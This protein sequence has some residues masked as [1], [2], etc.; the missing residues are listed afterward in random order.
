MNIIHCVGNEKF[1][2]GIIDVFELKAGHHVNRYVFFPE[3]NADKKLSYLKKN[4]DKVS[5]I[6]RRKALQYVNSM[7]CDV[8]F[9]HNLST[10]PIEDM[11]KI[12]PRIKVV[13]MS[14]GYD[15][16][17][18][19]KGHRPM[20]PIQQF[21]PLTQEALD[22]DWINR[23]RMLAKTTRWRLLSY[24]EKFET[25]V[26]RVDFF[27]SVIPWEYQEVK[28]NS[29]FRAEKVDFTY[30]DLHP[31]GTAETLSTPA[32]TGNNIL[33]GNSAGDTNNHL[34]IL[35]QLSHYILGDRKL[36]LPLSY[37]G[38]KHYVNLVVANG[39]SL[40]H[41]RFIPLNTFIPLAEYQ[42]LMS[43]CGYAIFAI[44]RQQALNNVW[45]ALWNGLM[46]FMSKRSPLY[47][48]L[49]QQG[50]LLFTTQDDLHLIAA[51]R[52]LTT[53]EITH[54]RQVFL[55]NDSLEIHLQKVEKLYQQLEDSLH[56]P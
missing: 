36:I 12:A 6:D 16:Y 14:W 26:H 55:Q 31:F 15:L 5:V 9:F 18:S 34:D 41:D 56:T 37:A 11:A 3:G 19:L 46:V 49:K 38:R 29:F 2:D 7:P 52:H 24:G 42:S 13:W 23:I 32:Q 33:V 30:F 43:S 10:F 28:K 39:K 1:I 53:E 17:A 48:H 44:E 54:N 47:Q 4:T 20:I 50:Y 45:M 40:F 35:D 21:L 51:E 8:L 22:K 27:S 25:G